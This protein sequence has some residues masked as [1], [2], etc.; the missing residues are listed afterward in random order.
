[1]AGGALIERA[2]VAVQLDS[3]ALL[4]AVVEVLEEVIEGRRR[5][6]GKLGEDERIGLI[7]HV[8]EPPQRGAE[9]S[10]PAS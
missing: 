5:L 10:R 1:V 4:E 6:V 9:Q 7:A 3:I 8:S 2:V